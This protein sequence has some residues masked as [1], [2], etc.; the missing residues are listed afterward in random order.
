MGF[1][2]KIKIFL[3]QQVR[4]ELEAFVRRQEPGED[5]HSRQL[6][7]HTLQLEEDGLYVCQ[8]LTPH[9]WKGLELL[10]K[11]LNDKNLAYT[12]EEI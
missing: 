12:V 5:N 1:E 11:F 8:Y 2:Y 6:P 7:L 4:Q 9:V 10:K 3:S